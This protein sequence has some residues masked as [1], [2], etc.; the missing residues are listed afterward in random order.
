MPTQEKSSKP[1]KQSSVSV[2]ASP[3]CAPPLQ[4]TVQILDFLERHR[5]ALERDEVRHN[6]M[7]GLLGRLVQTDHS[8]VRLWTLGAPGECAMQTTPRNAIILGELNETQCRA[9]AD[10]TLGLDYPGVVGCDPA[11][12]W[13]VERAVERGVRFAEPIPQ[14]IYSLR[15]RPSY[16]QVR[17]AARAVQV[18]D[19]ELFGQWLIAFF[20]EAAPYDSLPTPD[21]VQKTAAAGNYRFWIVDGGPVSMAGVVR[22]TRHGAAI[23]GVYTPLAL[24]GRG[25]AGAVTAALVDSVFAEGRTMACLYADLRNPASNRCYAKIGFKP[26]CRSWHYPRARVAG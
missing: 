16:P 22:R 15:D 14:Q 10:E 4:Q 3:A 23:A 21:G 8:E 2:R 9:L 17:G 19:A 7:L 24:R 26:V 11:A 20:E 1:T 25:Y 18:A 6:L 5:P 13:F 12:L